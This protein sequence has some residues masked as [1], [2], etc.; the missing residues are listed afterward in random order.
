MLA[1]VGHPVAVNPDK[2]L[3][4]A[5][6][7]RGW[8]I[9]RFTLEVPLRERVSMPAPKQAAMGG[10]AA[11]AAALAVGAWWLWRRG[12]VTAPAPSWPPRWPARRAR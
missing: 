10:G 4:K 7:D 11:A 12:A 6:K 3:A 5:A 2:E 9:E 1:A 8:L